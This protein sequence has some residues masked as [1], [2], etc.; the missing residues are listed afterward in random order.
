MG[1]TTRN[2]LRVKQVVSFFSQPQRSFCCF[3]L[4]TGCLDG[5][6]VITGL[7]SKNIN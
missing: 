5:V 6:C 7:P 2:I 4:T 3:I 1:I